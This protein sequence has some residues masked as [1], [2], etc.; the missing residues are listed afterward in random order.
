MCFGWV[1]L[2]PTTYVLVEKEK[3]SVTQS[4]I[5]RLGNNIAVFFQG[6]AGSKSLAA[7]P[8]E[9]IR[10]LLGV[11]DGHGTMLAYSRTHVIVKQ[12]DVMDLQQFRSTL[13]WLPYWE[14]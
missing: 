5:W 10:A 7:V 13:P 4:L 3:N 9:Q 2:V 11:V 6:V 1:F 12:M 8:L 14:Y